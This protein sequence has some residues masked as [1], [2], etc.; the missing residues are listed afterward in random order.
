MYETAAWIGS[1]CLA[2]CGAPQVIRSLRTRE[3]RGLSY[4]FLASWGLGEALL[5]IALVPAWSWPLFFNYT[6]NL[7]MV[8]TLIVLKIT[9]ERDV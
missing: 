6:L 1:L 8:I 4:G 3:V 9:G 7:I 2:Y 5:L